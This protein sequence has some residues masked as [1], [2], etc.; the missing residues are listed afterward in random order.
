MFYSPPSPHRNDLFCLMDVLESLGI[1]KFAFQK[2]ALQA[3]SQQ[4][5]TAN[6]Y[7]LFRSKI[8]HHGN[9]Y[10]KVKEWCFPKV[11]T[12]FTSKEWKQ[13]QFTFKCCYVGRCVEW[14]NYYLHSILFATA[15]H[16]ST[17]HIP[18]IFCVFMMSFSACVFGLILGELQV[19]V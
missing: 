6:G 8:P 16:I 17:C 5:T 15:S 12:S 11:V 1:P 13:A 4:A 9:M 7:S 10:P 19:T 3:T 14:W 18:Q 2:Y